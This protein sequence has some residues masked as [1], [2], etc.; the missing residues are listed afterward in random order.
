M[1]ALNGFTMID[2]RIVD[3]MDRISGNSVK[4]YLALRRCVNEKHNGN[5]DAFPAREWIME[6]TG[7]SENTI[8]MALNELKIFGALTITRRF[9]NSSIYHM[10]Y[11]ETSI[12]EETLIEKPQ[13][14][15]HESSDSTPLI[16]TK[17]N[18]NNNNNNLTEENSKDSTLQEEHLSELEVINMLDK[19]D[20]TIDYKDDTLV[21]A[22]DL[23]DQLSC[24]L[25][26]DENTLEED[27][28]QIKG[29]NLFD[30]SIP[31]DLDAYY[32][33]LM[34]GCG[35]FDN[36]VHESWREELAEI[37]RERQEWVKNKKADKRQAKLVDGMF[38][39]K[40]LSF[41]G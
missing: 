33:D 36:L 3:N 13:I 12:I 27:E 11:R 24:T 38:L 19:Q 5:E 2:N 6:K 34:I 4:V 25:K 35:T 30:T 8:K 21:N 40:K 15:I 28:N 41:G 31:E 7:L 26:S 29:T 22:M 32:T 23:E 14:L 16:I 9:N 20:I 17:N 39:G 18:N 37:E 1:N 10:N